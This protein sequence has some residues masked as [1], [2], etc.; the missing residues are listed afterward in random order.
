M[1]EI[2]K[3]HRVSGYTPSQMFDL[4]N[5]VEAY[6]QFLPW[7][8]HAAILERGTETGLDWI[9]A[10]LDLQTGPLTQSLTT[11]NT[12]STQPFQIKMTLVDGPFSS[13]TG[14]WTFLPAN[15]DRDKNQTAC[16]VTLELDFVLNAGLLNYVIEPLFSGIA[17]TMATAFLERAQA[18]Y[19]K[20]APYSGCLRLS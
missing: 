18:L 20:N 12:L 7:C 16:D 10:R 4:V 2:I 9:I 1:T 11:K 8:Q 19:E 13:L 6:P 15:D 14:L 3:R 5:H 17:N